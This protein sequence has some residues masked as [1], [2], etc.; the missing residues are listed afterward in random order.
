[1]PNDDGNGVA[2]RMSAFGQN[3]AESAILPL[4]IPAK[5][6]SQGGK[7]CSMM[8]ST[9]AF[10]LRLCFATVGVPIIASPRTC[11]PQ[12]K[13]GIRGSAFLLPLS[14]LQ[15]SQT[16]CRARGDGKGK[17]SNGVVCAEVCFRHKDRSF[18]HFLHASRRLQPASAH[19]HRS[20]GGR[21]TAEGQTSP[22]PLSVRTVRNGLRL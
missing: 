18:G 19:S 9:P 16:P 15:G 7:R 20:K 6:G 5:A 2:F 21:K 22:S 14:P 12:R 3:D 4:V 11:L 1:M 10:N 17:G 8:P 13:P